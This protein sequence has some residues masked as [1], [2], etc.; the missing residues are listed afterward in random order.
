MQ[1]ASETF[2]GYLTI[3]DPTELLKRGHIDIGFPRS[4]PSILTVKHS[5]KPWIVHVL[6]F[7]KFFPCLGSNVLQRG[8]D[9]AYVK[10]W[11]QL[12][13]LDRK[14]TPKADGGLHECATYIGA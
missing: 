9:P 5:G 13:A 11:E 3:K 7:W 14:S 12:A 4:K 2:L 8:L 6:Y 1:Q 10:Q